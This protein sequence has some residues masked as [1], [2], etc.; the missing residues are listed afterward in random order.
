TGVEVPPLD[1][2]VVEDSAADTELIVNELERAG[3][4]VWTERVGD[5]DALR[6]AL[7]DAHWDLIISD[8]VLPDFDSSRALEVLAEHGPEVPLI[9]VSPAIGEEAAVTALLR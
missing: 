8:H 9:V 2:L 5:A 7:A 3:F 1:V 6:D 4:E